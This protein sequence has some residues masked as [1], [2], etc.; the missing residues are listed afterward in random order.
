MRTSGFVR[1]MRRI[2]W[3]APWSA[4]A[5]TE[6]V[7]T[8]TSS[9]SPGGTGRPPSARNWRSMSTESAWFTR[10]PKVTTAYFMG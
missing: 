3:R 7:F 9:A 6:Q 4:V 5:V 10:Q 2:V 1:A 8:T